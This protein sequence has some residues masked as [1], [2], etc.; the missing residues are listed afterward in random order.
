MRSPYRIIRDVRV[1]VGRGGELSALRSTSEE[2][3]LPPDRESID[4]VPLEDVA[5]LRRK[6]SAWDY[7]VHR[8]FISS[9]KIV[10][11]VDFAKL[12]EADTLEISEGDVVLFRT[13]ELGREELEELR[14]TL[15]KVF[16]DNRVVVLMGDTGGV[17][18]R[19]EARARQIPGVARA[20][21]GM[22][23]SS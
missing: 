8:G 23:T 2:L 13:P 10:A 12:G 17:E 7:A 11:A 9:S 1:V 5:I 14:L 16:P 21:D 22:E 15:S 18:V 3:D 6:A 20:L 4:V 19:P